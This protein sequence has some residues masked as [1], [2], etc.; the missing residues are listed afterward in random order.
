MNASCMVVRPSGE[1]EAI[2]LAMQRLWLT[3]R[4]FPVGA[5]STQ[6]DLR[7]QRRTLASRNRPQGRDAPCFVV[8]S[9]HWRHSSAL[10]PLSS[11][12]CLT[13]VGWLQC[14]QTNITFE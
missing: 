3:G 14:G 7:R 9:P 8:F 13:R 4:V 12:V 10:V 11:T 1:R 2:R 6:L 5:P